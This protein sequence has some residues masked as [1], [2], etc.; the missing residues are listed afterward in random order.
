MPAVDAC[1]VLSAQ[2]LANIQLPP[3]SKPLNSSGEVEC[4][5]KSDRYI[6]DFAVDRTRTWMTI[7]PVPVLALLLVGAIVDAEG[8]VSQP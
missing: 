5:Y 6:V 7:S 8:K 1:T 4:T 3:Q 2:K